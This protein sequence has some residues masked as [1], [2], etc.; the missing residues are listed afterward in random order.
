[1]VSE[2]W[3]TRDLELSLPYKVF[4]K[5]NTGDITVTCTLR[6]SFISSVPGCADVVC[7]GAC[8]V[9]RGL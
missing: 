1:M 6:R 8:R 7:G 3:L 4:V 5:I 2:L 9:M